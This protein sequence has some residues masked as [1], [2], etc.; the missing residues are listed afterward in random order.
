MQRALPHIGNFS[1]Q[2]NLVRQEKKKRDEGEKRS[3]K[4]E[5]REIKPCLGHWAHLFFNFFLP[6]FS[7]LL[8]PSQSC[9][10]IALEIMASANDVVIAAGNNGTAAGNV[11]ASSPVVPDFPPPPWVHYVLLGLVFAGAVVGMCC[12]GAQQGEKKNQQ[13][14]A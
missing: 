12:M 2:Y 6:F 9:A 8:F 13:E 10:A 7:S 5:S 4:A 3:K 1:I 14:S 11:S